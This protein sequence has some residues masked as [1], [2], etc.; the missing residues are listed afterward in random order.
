MTGS[1]NLVDHEVT[2]I[3]DAFDAGD[4]EA[5]SRGLTVTD[6]EIVGLVPRSAIGEGDIEHVRLRGFD[7]D[8][9]IL[10]ALIE[11]SG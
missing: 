8:T 2:G 9:Q 6:S 10:E 7:P 11:G 5:R 1:M 4:T 3:R